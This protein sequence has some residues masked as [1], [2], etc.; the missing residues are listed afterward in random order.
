MSF[1]SKVQ[2]A[3]NAA[4]EWIARQP[5]LTAERYA[6]RGDT[7]PYPTGYD[8]LNDYADFIAVALVRGEG[9]S[10]AMVNGMRFVSG[11]TLDYVEIPQ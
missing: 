5:L 1:E 7:W 4:T 3:R 9:T 8:A 2:I 10:N 11:P 6:K